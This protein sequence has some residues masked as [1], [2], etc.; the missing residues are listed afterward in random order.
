MNILIIIT[1]A[2]ILYEVDGE[3]KIKIIYWIINKNRYWKVWWK[4]DT[5]NFDEF[6]RSDMKKHLNQ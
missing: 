2:T 1:N 3:K 6:S 5:G 4:I